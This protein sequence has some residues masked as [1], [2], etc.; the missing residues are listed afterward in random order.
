[1]DGSAYVG[2]GKATVLLGAQLGA[3][4]KGA[5]VVDFGCGE[6][7]ETLELLELGAEKVIGIDIQESLLEVARRRASI[8]QVSHLTEF[9]TEL[10]TPADLAV[11]LDGFEHFSNPAEILEILAAMLREGGRVLV[12]FGPTWYHPLGGHLFSVFPWAHIVLPEQSL[13]RWRSTFK[14]DGATRFSEVAGGLNRMTIARF[15]QVVSQSQFRFETF[16]TVPIRKLRLVHAPWSREFTSAIVRAT[17]RK[18]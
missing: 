16:E 9:A 6:G 11:S 14:S 13:I 12:S 3:L 4:V 18:S 5:T 17:L 7:Q 1:M 8:A 15:E 10:T 2:R